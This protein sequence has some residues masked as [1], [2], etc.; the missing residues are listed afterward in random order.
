MKA[1]PLIWNL[2]VLHPA[3]A[4][5]VDR[6]WD[7]HMILNP[8]P[9]SQVAVYSLQDALLRL[10]QRFKPMLNHR[11]LPDTREGMTPSFQKLG[12]SLW[13]RSR[14]TGKAPLS[15]DLTFHLLREALEMARADQKEEQ[16]GTN[17]RILDL[18]GK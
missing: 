6:S 10:Y 3:S 12:P 11:S 2:L 5:S 8:S 18:V 16:A 7:N 17:R 14:R 4:S 15:L 13:E 9:S 1:L